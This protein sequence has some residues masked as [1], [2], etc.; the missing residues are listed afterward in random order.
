MEK[1][2]KLF[3][4]SFKFCKSVPSLILCTLLYLL[5][6]L[7]AGLVISLLL[8][9]IVSMI[10]GIVLS[11]VTIFGIILFVVALLL[12]YTVIGAII[13]IPLAFISGIM[14]GLSGAVTGVIVSFVSSFISIYAI[15]GCVVAVLAYAGVFGE[16]TFPEKVESEET[17]E[18]YFARI[19][20]YIKEFEFKNVGTIECV[21]RTA[22][23]LFLVDDSYVFKS[24]KELL[25]PTVSD[26]YNDEV[27]YEPYYSIIISNNDIEQGK[28]HEPYQHPENEDIH[29]DGYYEYN[30][31]GTLIRVCIDDNN[32]IEYDSGVFEYDYYLEVRV[33]EY[34]WMDY[35]YEPQN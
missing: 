23:N 27:S 13:G 31:R 1:L 34:L 33:N 29:W 9:P 8:Q 17:A 22:G 5:I 35:S 32:T 7:A 24:T 20:D 18:E 15:A 25:E 30:L 10:I 2:K 21:W 6:E 11:P 3:P 16:I 28:Y 14:M 19:L 12:S 4:L 26:Y